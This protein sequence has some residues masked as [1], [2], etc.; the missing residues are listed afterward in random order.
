[1]SDRIRYA[2]IF[3]GDADTVRQYLPGNYHVLSHTDTETV[4]GGRDNA[5]WTLEDYVLP[6]LA[7]GLYHG[8][9]FMPDGPND[10]QDRQ[11]ADVAALSSVTTLWCR[12]LHNGDLLACCADDGRKWRINRDGLFVRVIDGTAF[13][14][15]NLYDYAED[16]DSAAPV[17]LLEISDDTVKWTPVR[18]NTVH[19]TPLVQWAGNAGRV[20]PG[21]VM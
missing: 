21:E 10:E 17:C 15:G 5:G 9:E 20:D 2:H 16:D 4:I 7:S 18:D 13:H 19:G 11:L 6:R 3:T 1:M 12:P 8:E 14:P